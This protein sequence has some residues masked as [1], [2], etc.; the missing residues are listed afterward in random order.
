MAD[1]VSGHAALPVD[2]GQPTVGR[3]ADPPTVGASDSGGGSYDASDIDVLEG[4]EAVR[5][6]PG[7]Y[8][9]STGQAGLHHLVYEIVD[10]SVDEAM[11]GHATRIDI[12]LQP[13]GWVQVRDDGRGIPTDQHAKTGK[14]ALETVLT[15]LHA[16]G[17]F[18]G[19]G[20]KVSGG[21]HGVGASV[22]NA[23]ASQL[24]VEVRR[25]RYS[26]TQTYVRGVPTGGVERS[27]LRRGTTPSTGTMVRWV[28]DDEVIDH[29]EYDFHTLAQRFREIAYLNKGLWICFRDERDFPPDLSEADR[30]AREPRE[31]TNFYFE[32]GIQSY[33]RFLNRDREVLQ[34]LPFHLD[35]EVGSNGSAV[36]VEVAIQ[37]NGDFQDS[38]Y[39][40]A[41]TI[42]THEGGSHLTGFR[43]ALT[44]AINDFARRNKQLGDKDPNI[45]GEDTREGLTAV[46][47]VKL[48]EPQFEGQ[49]K[50]KLGNPEIKGIVESATAEAL[51]EYLDGQ[52]RE[53]RRIVEKCL[54][55]ARAREAARK[56]RAIV[57]RK[58]ALEGASLPGKLA[59]CSERSPELSELFIVE[60]DSA[61]GS[62]KQG[63]DRR[64]QAILPLRGKVLNVERARLDKLLGHEAYRTLITALGTGIGE[65]FDLSKLRYHKVVIMTDADS[66]G[67]HIRTLLLTFFFRHMRELLDE[68]KLY[69]A[70]P[71]L[72]RVQAGR[73]Q[74]QW[75]YSDA[76]LEAFMDKQKEGQKKVS[77]QRYKGLGEMNADQLWETTMDP[78]ARVLWSVDV[79]D[80]H[81]AD[82]LFVKLMGDDPA[83]RRHFIEQH[84]DMARIDV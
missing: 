12:A 32:G 45:T 67:A 9:G 55:T 25:D 29:L 7:M 75:L 63:R 5:R 13:G 38:V 82:D 42:N 61:G 74:A 35:R 33:V 37:Y 76:E 66:D 24:E 59:D 49:T 44:R 72:Y 46:I 20:Y 51:S 11:A 60:G 68:G 77:V 83:K 52:P 31:E 16:G 26:Y 40:F 56:A 71:P 58:G 22:V 23:L 50:T 34:G 1:Q 2:D 30:A 18:G 64:T 65:D 27:K 84:A 3:E 21:L 4:I 53:G 19:G 78:Q 81:A 6:R 70:Q 17:K 15:V 54:T 48:G 14:S 10:N 69:I 47:S 73:Q 57:Q 79:A 28:A 43:S 8:I 80:E 39:A 41:N 36:V 62:A